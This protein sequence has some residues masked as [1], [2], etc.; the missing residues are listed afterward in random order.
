MKFLIVTVAFLSVA[1]GMIINRNGE[2]KCFIWFGKLLALGTQNVWP[3]K[4]F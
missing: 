4:H 3:P 2:L 1:S